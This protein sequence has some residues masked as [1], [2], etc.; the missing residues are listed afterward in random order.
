MAD[1][2]RDLAEHE[3]LASD[4]PIAD[5]ALALGFGNPPHFTRAFRRW[6][7]VPPS[8]RRTDQREIS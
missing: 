6:T 7:G 4:R 1:V 5:L 8:A 3:L 2:L